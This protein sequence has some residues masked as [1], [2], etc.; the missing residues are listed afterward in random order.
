LCRGFPSWCCDSREQSRGLAAVG[1][2][3]KKQPRVRL[4]PEAYWELSRQ[5]LKRDNWKCQT[6]RAM[7]NL[8]VHHLEFQSHLGQLL[9][10][11]HNVMRAMPLSRSPQHQLQVPMITP[12]KQLFPPTQFDSTSQDSPNETKRPCSIKRPSF[13]MRPRHVLRKMPRTGTAASRAKTITAT[14]SPR[15]VRSGSR[16]SSSAPRSSMIMIFPSF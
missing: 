13:Q 11:R 4:V 1:W 6:C 9:R 16:L 14:I 15:S 12:L 5:V 3:S 7:R 8:Q 2:I 10:A